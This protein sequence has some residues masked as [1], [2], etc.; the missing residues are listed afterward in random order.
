MRYLSAILVVALVPMLG[1]NFDIA[2]GG[3]D[4]DGSFNSN[5]GDGADPAGPTGSDI[6]GGDADPGG[7]EE[8][9]TGEPPDPG[10]EDP[11]D[12]QPE[13]PPVASDEA[14][15]DF[16]VVDVNAESARYLQAVSPRDYLGQVSAWYF[17]HST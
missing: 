13:E 9:D 3:P 10:T 14:L 12:A 4:D 2:A 16:S 7:G 15:P 1:C 6:G 11:P 8:P 5:S 17:G